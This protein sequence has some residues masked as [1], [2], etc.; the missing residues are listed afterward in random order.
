MVRRSATGRRITR[1]VTVTKSPSGK[2]ISRKVSSPSGGGGSTTSSPSTSDRVSVVRTDFLGDGKRRITFSDG[3]VR[4]TETSDSGKTSTTSTSGGGAAVAIRATSSGQIVADPTG[5]FFVRPQAQQQPRLEQPSAAISETKVTTLQPTITE[6][7]FSPAGMP[8]FI[9]RQPEAKEV[10]PTFSPVG[11]PTFIGKRQPQ[12]PP[13]LDTTIQQ[14]VT[15]LKET[16]SSLDS[17]IPINVKGKET[18]SK[19][20]GVL[21][22]T[23]T[24]IPKAQEKFPLISSPLG[25]TARQTLKFQAVV[26]SLLFGT[27]VVSPVVTGGITN[28]ISGSA[29]GKT[30][31]AA[32]TIG[33]RLIQAKATFETLKVG[34]EFLSGTKEQKAIISDIGKEDFQAIVSSGIETQAK[35]N[36]GEVVGSFLQ[37]GF[38]SQTS[39]ALGKTVVRGLVPSLFAA[40]AFEAETTAKFQELGFTGRKLEQAVDVSTQFKGA[41]DI[42]FTGTLL[43][44]EAIANV[45]GGQVAG[46][47]GLSTNF[48][49][50]LSKG[51]RTKE[52]FK[53]RLL[54]GF[55]EGSGGVLAELDRLGQKQ[56]FP[57]LTTTEITGEPIVT[58]IETID[59]ESGAKLT[60]I[61]T[62][63]PTTKSFSFKPGKLAGGLTG[64]V[65]GSLAAG[66]FSGIVEAPLIGTRAGRIISSTIGFTLDPAEAPGD[67]LTPLLVT[68]P[69]SPIVSASSASRAGV[70]GV[71]FSFEGKPD[72]TFTKVSDF[73]SKPFKTKRGQAS[74]GFGEVP[75]SGK[76]VKA[77]GKEVVLFPSITKTKSTDISTS[78]TRSISKTT[79]NIPAVVPSTTALA[80]PSATFIDTFTD[81]QTE[82]DIPSRTDLVVRTTTGVP[83]T[84]F[85]N[86]D[87]FVN[88]FVDTFVTTPRVLIPPLPGGG[89]GGGFGFGRRKARRPSKFQPSL[90][91]VVTGAKRQKKK[92]FLTGF[93]VRGTPR[94]MEEIK[95]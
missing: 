68:T 79:T 56:I 4:V 63:T 54:P 38:S 77:K 66:T 25:A 8:L 60:E 70:T 14:G 27:A 61:V 6:G 10:T 53:A 22:K 69:T 31:A 40:P 51:T 76:P 42:A 2:T 46:Q 30:T 48:L 21:A 1:T 20:T 39:A 24:A 86:V 72:V 67:F 59:P 50:T 9:G 11:M 92:K 71:T 81:V 94:I 32:I 75:F 73:V 89:G 80:I 18:L 87:T 84:T 26:G 16:F 43:Q 83:S 95:F 78:I 34:Q 91:G 45:V 65:F 3:S 12:P 29:A 58:T 17:K 52:L 13:A 47:R 90:V 62:E 55:I 23:E 36:V 64:G 15:F 49:K 19:I 41:R 82:I 28:I 44:L 7:E 85:T 33:G 35:A 5:S 57:S 88:N 74:L 93:E 37:T